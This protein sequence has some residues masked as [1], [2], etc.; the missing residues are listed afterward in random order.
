MDNLFHTQVFPSLPPF[1][2][3][4]ILNPE[5]QKQ[6]NTNARPQKYTSVLYCTWLRQQF[7]TRARIAIKSARTQI[8]Q[9]PHYSRCTAVYLNLPLIPSPKDEMMKH[10]GY[11]P[12]PTA[13][14]PY[15]QR[16]LHQ[17]AAKQHK[18]DGQ[19][20]S[21]LYSTAKPHSQICVYFYTNKFRLVSTAVT[22]AQ[23]LL[24][25][26]SQ[27]RYGSLQKG[28]GLTAGHTACVCVLSQTQT[29][30]E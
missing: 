4:H 16:A 20:A 21:R 13:I 18:K 30:Y 9:I 7:G 6:R 26:L 28:C 15:S 8:P 17:A 10:A 3:R 12:L 11:F 25:T 14:L 29:T 24:A 27:F 23:V 22:V 2:V 19:L 5:T 1:Q